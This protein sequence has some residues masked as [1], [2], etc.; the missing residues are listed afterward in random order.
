MFQHCPKFILEQL[1][2]FLN[3]LSI[4]AAELSALLHYNLLCAVWLTTHHEVNMHNSGH[5]SLDG[6]YYWNETELPTILSALMEKVGGQFSMQPG[7]WI[8]GLEH[9]AE[10]NCLTPSTNEHGNFYATSL[11]LKDL[12]G[13]ALTSFV[14]HW[15]N[16]A[17]SFTQGGWFVQLDVHGGA[18]SAVSAVPNSATAYAHR[19]KIFLVQFYHFSV[20]DRL[21]PS[22]GIDVLKGWVNATIETLQE[23]DF[24]MYINYADSQLD[25]ETA[26]NMYWG[27][28]LDRLRMIKKKFDP[29][30]L[31][32]YPQSIEPA[33]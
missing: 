20:D 33:K 2:L 19:D 27:G 5:H 9:Y 8:Q 6:V 1:V 16:H 29:T 12:R 10:R 22:G 11:T 17:L 13:E 7:T 18:N 23:G 14:H 28:N 15:H 26:E 32:Y 3:L 21:Y 31:F 25:R 30:E 24:G 4:F